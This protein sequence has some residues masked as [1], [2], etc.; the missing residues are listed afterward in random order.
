MASIAALVPLKLNS[1][2]LPN[3]N[4]M[5]LGDYPLAYH[6]FNTLLDVDIIDNVYC[7]SSQSQILDLLPYGVDFLVRPSRLDGDEVKANELFLYAINKLDAE[8][9]VL[10]HATAPFLST[11]TIE[12]GLEKVL[13]GEY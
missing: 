9:I 10:C 11:K 7:Y 1:R 3:K 8:W 12:I 6:I 2:R 13:S 4:F 5:R